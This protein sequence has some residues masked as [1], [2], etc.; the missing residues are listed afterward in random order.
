[1][2]EDARRRMSIKADEVIQRQ[3]EF[4]DKAHERNINHR[5]QENDDEVELDD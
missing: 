2:A 3:Q 1:M 5:Y 4:F